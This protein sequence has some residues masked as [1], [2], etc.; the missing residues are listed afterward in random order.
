MWFVA[1]ALHEGSVALWRGVALTFR[2]TLLWRVHM[3]EAPTTMMVTPC[4]MTAALTWLFGHRRAR[5]LHGA[6]WVQLQT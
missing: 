6:R 3:S 1:N 5:M 4:R 2:P